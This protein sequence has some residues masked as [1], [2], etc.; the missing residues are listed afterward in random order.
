MSVI[1]S[2]FKSVD[3]YPEYGKLWPAASELVGTYRFYAIMDG[4]LREIDKLEW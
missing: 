3:V 4:T 2:C 1:S